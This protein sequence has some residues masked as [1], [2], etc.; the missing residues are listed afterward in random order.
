M[1]I[2]I[3]PMPVRHGQTPARRLLPAG[4]RTDLASRTVNRITGSMMVKILSPGERTQVRA[5]GKHKNRLNDHP[6]PG[7]LL[8]GEGETFAVPLKI[9]ARLDLPDGIPKFLFWF[10]EVNGSDFQSPTLQNC[11]F[12]TL[13]LL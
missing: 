9:Y 10:P 5:G 8:Q 1:G 4:K 13:A 12:E 11:N 2:D 3:S 7:P 6:H